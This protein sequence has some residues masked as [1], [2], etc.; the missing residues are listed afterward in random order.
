MAIIILRQLLHVIDISV[1]FYGFNSESEYHCV[2][3]YPGTK[4]D[5]DDVF[6]YKIVQVKYYSV[7]INFLRRTDQ[8][9]PNEPYERQSCD[10]LNEV[11]VFLER[12]CFE[13]TIHIM[14]HDDDFSTY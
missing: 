12:K 2:L 13:K 6:T 10:T 7:F 4:L 8:F 3:T 11:G 9:F 14:L 1:A 5:E